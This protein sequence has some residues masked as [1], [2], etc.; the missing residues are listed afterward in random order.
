VASTA[1]TLSAEAAAAEKKK[2][3]KD[4][5]RSAWISFTGR[6]VA[7]IAGAAATIVIGL[8]FV[9]RAH[10]PHETVVNAARPQPATV[11]VRTPG[12]RALAVLPLQNFSGSPNEDYLADGLTEALIADLTQFGG[13]RVI[14]RT[15]SMFY[16]GQQK[17]LP[18]IANEL[19]VDLI[20]EG[21][22]VKVGDRVRV[23]AQLIDAKR[24]EH[25]WA[26]RYDQASKDMLSVQGEVAREIAREVTEVVS[27]ADAAGA[28]AVKPAVYDHLARR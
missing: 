10:A 18:E 13:V 7:Q 14:S 21:S 27:G 15:S 17:S 16:K 28:A 19:E 20:V 5:V 23:T 26:R 22:I 4:K 12:E 24:D 2:R 1:G 25:L 9:Q 8:S 11:R 6:I 3:K